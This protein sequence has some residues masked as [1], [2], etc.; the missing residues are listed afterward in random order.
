MNRLFWLLPI[1]LALT[2]CTSSRVSRY[3]EFEKVKVDKM[4]GNQVKFPVLSRTVVCLNG[5]R[6]E[7]WP[8]T[9]TNQT[10]SF[11]TNLVPA[12]VTNITVT[13]SHNSQLAGNTNVTAAPTPVA[14][15]EAAPPPVMT[16]GPADTSSKGVTVSTASNESL[17]TGP[18]QNVISRSEQTVT[19]YSG[20]ATVNTNNQAITGGSNVVVTVETN[21]LITTVTN[22]VVTAA[23]NVTVTSPDR[24]HFDYYLY[25]EVAP[26]DFTITPGESL[27]VLA[28]GERFGLT[29][30]QPQS[31]WTSRRGYVTTFYK[32]PPEALSSI[33][34]AREVRIRIRG[35]SG[36]LEH[37]LSAASRRHF[38]TFL[39][40]GFGETGTPQNV[41]RGAD[42]N[43]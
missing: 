26:P 39:V 38:R 19:M 31:G 1:F 28:D 42:R 12:S 40:R 2:A 34:N 32:A 10:V 16:T 36:T 17:A 37:K 22:P 23:T 30:A 27:V 4:V 33:A 43:S 8:A 5:M 13:R 3:D 20:Q 15:P 25:T 6:E 9:V 18:S 14:G 7:V 41:Q 21:Y 35:T 29:P 24:P 11:T